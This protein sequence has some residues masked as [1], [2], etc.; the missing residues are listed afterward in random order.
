MGMRD[1]IKTRRYLTAFALVTTLSCQRFPDVQ[2]LSKRVSKNSLH[3][4][5]WV[6]A[7]GRWQ[8][9]A[10]NLNKSPAINTLEIWC[11]KGLGSCRETRAILTTPK[12][13]DFQSPAHLFT[14]YHEYRI[15][16]WSD[17]NLIAR[18]ETPA[19]DIDL[20]ISVTDKVVEK[21]WRETR[22]RGNETADPNN[23]L[24]ES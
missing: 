18:E 12:D 8:K 13:S 21:N 23:W 1:L 22:A 15:V 10:G 17:G 2:V 5:E 14:Y 16:S 6:S 24:I 20:K 4:Q 19:F 11:D 3:G 9:S 7:T